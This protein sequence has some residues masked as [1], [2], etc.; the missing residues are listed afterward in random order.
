MDPDRARQLLERERERIERDLAD[1]RTARDGGDGELADV[2]QHNADAGTELFDEERD[3]SLIQRMERD[4]DAIAQAFKRLDEGT[5]GVS[6][7]SG[8]PI[9]DDRL[10]LVPWADRTVEE[11]ARVDAESRNNG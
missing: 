7:D 6:V 2:D 8:A 11:Q 3:Q 9:P 1:L 5:Y 10:E 4:L